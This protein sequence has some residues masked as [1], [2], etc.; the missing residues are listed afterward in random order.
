MPVVSCAA[1]RQNP[2]D[3]IFSQITNSCDFALVMMGIFLNTVALP[4]LSC[5]DRAANLIGSHCHKKAQGIL[6]LE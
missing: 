3:A 4:F 5:M 2:S 1:S 6:I